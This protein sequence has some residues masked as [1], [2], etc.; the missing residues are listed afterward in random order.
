MAQ[1][2]VHGSDAHWQNHYEKRNTALWLEQHRAPSRQERA[3]RRIDRRPA[4][5]VE[6]WQLRL[7][8]ANR[9]SRTLRQVGT[10][11]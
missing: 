11:R 7:P 2:H 3:S 6:T 10:S 5:A 4:S 1:E 9:N 8:F